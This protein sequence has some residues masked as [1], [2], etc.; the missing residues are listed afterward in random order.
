MAVTAAIWKHP[1]PRHPPAAATVAIPF[2]QIYVTNLRMAN[3]LDAPSASVTLYNTLNVRH[4][5]VMAAP[6]A[7]WA[8]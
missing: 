7:A 3:A 1:H 4:G 8:P 2:M 5:E 6:W